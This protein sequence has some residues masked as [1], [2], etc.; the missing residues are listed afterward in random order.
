MVCVFLGEGPVFLS[1]GPVA[2]L[3]ADFFDVVD[4][5]DIAR[6]LKDGFKN[7]RT[8]CSI[9]FWLGAPIRSDEAYP[10]SRVLN[11]D[12]FFESLVFL[13]WLLPWVR[14]GPSDLTIER[15]SYCLCS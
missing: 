11:E 15:M 4:V 8:F 10:D 12:A 14:L 1:E 6:V 13:T 3:L 9:Y 5:G 7:E 2:F